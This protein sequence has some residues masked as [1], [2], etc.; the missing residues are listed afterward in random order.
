MRNKEVIQRKLE[1]LA[2][3]IKLV[4][5]SFKTNDSTNG[6]KYIDKTLEDIS[7]INTLLNTET[8]D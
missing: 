4:G 1:R 8:Q 7:D 5:Y 6:Y 2:A 3:D